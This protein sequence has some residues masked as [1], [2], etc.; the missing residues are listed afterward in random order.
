MNTTNLK[1]RELRKLFKLL[2]SDPAFAKNRVESHVYDN[3]TRAKVL[4]RVGVDLEALW[5]TRDSNQCWLDKT[6]GKRPTYRLG[7][8]RV[9]S[10][11]PDAPTTQHDYELLAMKRA[12]K[13]R[14][15]FATVVFQT[16]L[17]LLR[18]D[19]GNQNSWVC[20]WLPKP[21]KLG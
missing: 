3:L 10:K 9:P 14:V 20:E 12:N 5:H 17:G 13:Q 2:D 18:L 16:P 8:T 15:P 1:D 4:K 19:W 7:C 11:R 6:Y 21:I